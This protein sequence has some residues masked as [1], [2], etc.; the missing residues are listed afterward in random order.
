MADL[1][2]S[3]RTGDRREGRQLRTLNAYQRLAPYLLRRRSEAQCS[4][5][6]SVEVGG[7]EQWLRQ[8]RAEG[9]T[10]LGFIHLLVAAY[11]RTVSM[12]PGINRFVSGRKLYARNEVQVV[13]S[14]KRGASASAT[15]TSVKVSFS[16]TDTVFDVYRRLS[17]AVDGV[18]ADVA[19][20]EPERIA[21]LLMRLPRFLV[22]AV[23]AVAR[24]LDYFDWLPRTWLD[25]SP[26][27]GSLTVIDL[28]S[29]GV[30]PADHTLPDFGNIP[31]AISFGARRKVRETGEDGEVKERHY[32][33]Y[34]VTCDERIVDSYYYASALKCLKYFMKNP[35]H[36]ELPPEAVEDD[37]N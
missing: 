33:D 10:G 35:M 24:A 23:T 7:V 19:V 36:L 8:K 31:C 26:F 28:G 6:D 17:E 37:V 21:G 27:H 4:I 9:W 20:S 32:V 30:V 34:R 1:G 22:R 11:V 3:K 29:L 15:E 13:L 5:S 2:Y 18:K 25:A 14:V 12:R 16:P